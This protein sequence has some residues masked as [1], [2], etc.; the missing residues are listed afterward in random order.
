MNHKAKLRCP[1]LTLVLVSGACAAQVVRSA[2]KEL[3]A[4]EGR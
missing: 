4:G 1:A 2:P 3:G